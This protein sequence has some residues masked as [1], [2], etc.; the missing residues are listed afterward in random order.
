MNEIFIDADKKEL[1]K[2]AE[3]FYTTDKI[4][5]RDYIRRKQLCYQEV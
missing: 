3:I 2:L 5:I 4:I 1:D